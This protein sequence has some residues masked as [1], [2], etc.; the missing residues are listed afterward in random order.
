MAVKL[1]IRE[2]H[3]DSRC[4]ACHTTN[5]GKTNVAHGERFSLEF[6]V[7]CEACHGPAGDWL[8]AHTQKSWRTLSDLQKAELGFRDLQSAT[9]RADAC[10]VCHVGS[11][12]ATVDHDLIA[13]GHPRLTF[14]LAAYHSM[15]PKHWN[16]R[17]ELQ[18]DPMQEVRLWAIGQATTAK[19]T[20]E[21]SRAR[22]QAAL[23][24]QSDRVATDLAEFDCHSCHHD[25]AE[26]SWRVNR[27]SLGK[28]G[29]PQWGTWNVYSAVWL[30]KN[31]RLPGANL[32]DAGVET[33]FIELQKLMQSSRLGTVRAE[34]LL[35]ASRQANAA[36]RR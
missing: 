35:M 1:G 20:T 26:E 12:S 2:A 14:E 25:L 8:S 27:W 24:K 17:E 7:G 6:G 22:A 4:L 16:A 36:L 33:S 23:D 15:L 5:A 18:R 11:E 19:V 10:A 13:A 29:A 34:P 21:I 9:N 3:T 32:S 31:G 30:A 28:L